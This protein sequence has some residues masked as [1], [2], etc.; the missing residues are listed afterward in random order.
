ML[1]LVMG[2]RTISSRHDMPHVVIEQ[3]WDD[4]PYQLR[5]YLVLSMLLLITSV[6]MFSVGRQPRVCISIRIASIV[7]T[8]CASG[9]RDF[10]ISLESGGTEIPE[11]NRND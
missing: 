5:I 8:S 6:S 2:R 9:S 7:I 1:T 3:C 10:I 4:T 11:I